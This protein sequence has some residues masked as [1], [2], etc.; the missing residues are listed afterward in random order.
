MKAVKLILVS[1]VVFSVVG[2]FAATALAAP[3]ATGLQ[4]NQNAT[5]GSILTDDQGM[6]VYIFK[7]DK[8]GVSNCS[9]GCAQNW[10]AL[11]VTDDGAKPVLAQGLAGKIATISRADG[12]VQVTFNDWPLYYFKMDVKPGDALG[13]GKGGVWEVIKISDAAPAAPASSSGSW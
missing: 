8:P 3:P 1:L 2:A 11:T 7:N 5:L 9:G 6:T 12:S 10:P 4:S 13:E